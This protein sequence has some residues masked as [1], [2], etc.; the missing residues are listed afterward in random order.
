MNNNGYTSKCLPQSIFA[1][2]DFQKTATWTMNLLSSGTE[3]I[4]AD[5][6]Q[7]IGAVT[8]QTVSQ[9]SPAYTNLTVTY[10]PGTSYTFG[11]NYLTADQTIYVMENSAT[12]IL[13]DLPCSFSGST[14]ISFSTANYMTSTVPSWVAI[15][16]GSGVLSINAPEVSMDTEYDF[17]INSTVSGVSN[18]IQKLIMLTITNCAAK[19][20]KKCINTN[21]LTCD[22]CVSGYALT[23]GMWNIPTVSETA[24]ALSK[25][26][27]SAVITI[28][29]IVVLTSII[30]TTSI[31]NLW[32]TINQLQLF[33]LL[34]LTRAYIPKDVQVLIEGFDFAS[35]IYEY[36]SIYKLN[37]NPSF[38]RKF[39]FD[40]TNQSLEPL[41]INYD[42]TFANTSSVLVYTFLMVLI[43]LLIYFIRKLAYKCRESQRC[44]WGAKT[45]YWI[46][47]KLYRMMVLGYFIRNGLEMSQF[48]L[49]SSVNE[50][51][52]WNTTDSYRLLSFVF[53]ISMILIFVLVVLLVLYLTF[54]KYR[55]NERE[56]N[57]F[58]EFFRGIQQNK[59][60]KFY[61]TLLLLRRFLFVILLITWLFISS[62][63]LIIVLSLIQVVYILNL[64][65][66]RPYQET[67]GNLIE[68]LNE[69]YFGFLVIFLS[70]VNT[71]DEWNSIKT[72]TYMWVLVSNTIVLLVIVSGKN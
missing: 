36:F 12:Q 24:K 68:I 32:M 67:K 55:L 43:S 2:P 46:V 51:Y 65:Y 40:L 17:Y 42:S 60:H 52:Q 29:G 26:T 35:N 58:E 13:P 66:L 4:V 69:I 20:W 48:I 44:S 23:S 49:I 39:E 10:V 22:S 18:P 70:I 64:S 16:S 25:T 30:N 33:L 19:N 53:S 54:S 72:N 38:L 59:R 37:M 3:D 5:S 50:I 63:V 62:R 31:A 15:D 56:H 1:H 45:Q 9:P 28:T 11:V 41:D 6:G 7:T 27:T 71:E 57:L 14:S 61:V 34:L 47:D 21:S 8:T